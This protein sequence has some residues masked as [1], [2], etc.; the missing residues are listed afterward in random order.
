[1]VK[2]GKKWKKSGGKS[3]DRS[4]GKKKTGRNDSIQPKV[5]MVS[6]LINKMPVSYTH[7]TLPTKR[8]V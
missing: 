1:M 6:T 8:I 2:T 5:K 7:L 4:I 3:A